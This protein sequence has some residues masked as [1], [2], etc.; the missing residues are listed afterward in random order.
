MSTAAVAAAGDIAVDAAA[1]R[2]TA[3]VSAPETYCGC[4]CLSRNYF[5]CGYWRSLPSCLSRATLSQP[6]PLLRL[7]A[8]VLPSL[9]ALSPEASGQGMAFRSVRLLSELYT[10]NS[11]LQFSRG[12]INPM[13]K[14]FGDKVQSRGKTGQKSMI[15]FFVCGTSIP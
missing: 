9:T 10:D 2:N 4:C 13:G 11:L 8:P 3:A 6:L 7:H 15:S 14:P 5:C 1:G 12:I